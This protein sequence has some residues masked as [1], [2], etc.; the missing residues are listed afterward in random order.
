MCKLEKKEQI[1]LA[2]IEEKENEKLAIGINANAGDAI[3]I[4]DLNP[5]SLS[6]NTEFNKGNFYFIIN[7][8]VPYK[9][10][11]FGFLGIFNYL[12]K[13][14]TGGFYFCN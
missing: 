11:G 4:G 5:G 1:R 7:L 9:P 3:P 2:K 13:T 14:K 6:F 12:W 10:W 8:N